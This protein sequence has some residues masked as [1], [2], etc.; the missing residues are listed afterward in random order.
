MEVVESLADFW[1][2]TDPFVDFWRGLFKLPDD[3]MRLSICLIVTYPA[4]L[5]HRFV[6][7]G[8]KAR[9]VFS[10]F[11]GL[12]WAFF[13][14]K[15]EA[16]Y[17]VGTG[18]F[19]Y[20][21]CWLLPSK[22]CPRIVVV[23]SFA[24]LSYGHWTRF[25]Y[26]YLVY[27]INW[28]TPM[29]LF[30]IKLQS[31]AWNVHDGQ[32]PPSKI[33]PAKNRIEKLPSL[34][35]YFSWLFF[36]AGFLTGPVGEFQDYISFTDRSMFKAE[37]NGQIPNSWKPAF[38]KFLWMFVGIFGFYGAKLLPESYCGSLEFLEHPFWYRMIYLLFAVE[39]GFT[40]YYFAWF[41]GEAHTILIGAAYNGRTKSGRTLWN[42]IQMLDLIPFR[43]AHTRFMIA[44]CWNICSSEWLKYY[45][46]L[47][48]PNTVRGLVH[49]VVFTL[50]VSA[51]WH[52]FYPGYYLFFAGYAF[53]YLVE[54]GVDRKFK[55]RY[56]V[57][58]RG[59]DL[60]PISSLR[61]RIY[62]ACAT[63]CTWTYINSITISFRLLD[64]E[65]TKIAWGAIYYWPIIAA[66]L[67]Y[68][69]FK[70]IPLPA[71]PP[72]TKKD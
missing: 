35:E 62:I 44:G 19:T 32:K 72:E 29:M 10:L 5:L 57:K 23:V 56:V 3:M 59:R 12:F 66:F 49:P 2:F 9:L 17:Y 54:E 64:W 22:H 48:L 1:D 52:G 53:Y 61:Y 34:L 38:Q 63:L 4:V 14:F 24:V 20:L 36:F 55:R 70:F 16:L 41:N 46:Y 65:R 26:H 28:C 45:V 6:M 47:R 60:K 43:L 71:P 67:L 50:M 58:G 37:P 25:Q 18:L 42:R 7:P 68:V 33:F 31:F 15:W 40:K 11:V 51:Y 39:L 27:Y 69:V 30:C 8:T 13:C 21:A